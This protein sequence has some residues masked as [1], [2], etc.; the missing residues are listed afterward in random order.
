MRPSLSSASVK[1]RTNLPSQG[2]VEEAPRPFV[3]RARDAGDDSEPLVEN[4]RP[5]EVRSDNIPA[6]ALASAASTAQPTSRATTGAIRA[7]SHLQGVCCSQSKL[8]RCSASIL[9]RRQVG[10]LLTV[11]EAAAI[12]NVSP[13][14]VRRLIATGKI[15]A[16]WV[17][18]L[19]RIRPRDVERLIADGGICND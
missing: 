11:A 3:D 2:P 7:N 14:T 12:L 10:P 15:G 17:R 5:K 16:V 19:V 1:A 4:T 13:R 6:W 8:S 9:G 18:R